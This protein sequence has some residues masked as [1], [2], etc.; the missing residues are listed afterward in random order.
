MK[1]FP[2]SFSSNKINELIYK[3]K[4]S[5]IDLILWYFIRPVMRTYNSACVI[6]MCVDNDFI[7]TGN[8]NVLLHDQNVVVYVAD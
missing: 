5:I 1:D 8:P 3:Q 7:Y 4:I 2:L 6:H